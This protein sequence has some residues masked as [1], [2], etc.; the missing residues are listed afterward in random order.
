L[1][2]IQKERMRKFTILFLLFCKSSI[3][4]SQDIVLVNREFHWNSYLSDTVNNKIAQEYFPIYKS[5]I[6]SLLFK[7]TP[8]LDLTK[9]GLNKTYINESDYATGHLSFKIRNIEGSYG[10]RYDITLISKIDK[11]TYAIRLNH[12]DWTLATNR[13]KIRNLIQYLKNIQQLISTNK[14]KP[15]KL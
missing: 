2:A 7:V 6:D 3:L 12:P 10:D 1:A 8:L 14:L 5:E 15:Y 9:M 13:Q 4:K 11:E